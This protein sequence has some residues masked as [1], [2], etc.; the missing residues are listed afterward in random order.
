MHR[1]DAGAGDPLRA[2]LARAVVQAFLEAAPVEVPAV[3][4]RRED[5]RQ[6]VDRVAPPHGTVAVTRQVAVAREIVPDAEAL[7]ERLRRGSEALARLVAAIVA[8][9]EHDRARSPAREKG[10]RRRCGMASSHESD[11]V[12]HRYVRGW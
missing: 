12:R 8:T 11:R 6:L 10:S 4:V 3:A 1:G 2:R 5:E 9:F 7:E